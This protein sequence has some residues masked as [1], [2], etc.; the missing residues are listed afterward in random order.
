MEKIKKIDIFF[1]GFGVAIL[2]LLLISYIFHQPLFDFNKKE[3][4]EVKGTFTF[5]N[6]SAFNEDTMFTFNGNISFKSYPICIYDNSD[7][8]IGSYCFNSN[9]TKQIIITLWKYMPRTK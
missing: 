6:Y 7:T 9:E 8:Q 2:M 1:M 4:P 3:S 5:Q